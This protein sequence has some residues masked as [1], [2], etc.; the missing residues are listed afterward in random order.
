MTACTHA[1]CMPRANARGAR[2]ATLRGAFIANCSAIASPRANDPNDFFPPPPA[3]PD[4]RIG[5]VAWALRTF[6]VTRKA[7]ATRR[8]LPK[9]IAGAEKSK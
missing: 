6:A 8:H 5:A 3:P 7:A 2:A 1:L 4:T 9:K